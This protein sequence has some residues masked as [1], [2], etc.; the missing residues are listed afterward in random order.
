MST[1]RRWGWFACDACAQLSVNA[2]RRELRGEPYA[3]KPHVRFGEGGGEPRLA[4]YL[5]GFEEAVPK[6]PDACVIRG[7]ARF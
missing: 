2:L 7:Y 1:S 3:G 4:P 6:A 5:Y